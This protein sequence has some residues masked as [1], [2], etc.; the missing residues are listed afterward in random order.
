[1]QPKAQGVTDTLKKLTGTLGQH[2]NVESKT[3][4]PTSGTSAR[5]ALTRSGLDQNKRNGWRPSS[6]VSN[7]SNTFNSRAM[8]T[9]DGQQGNQ[10]GD[11]RLALEIAEPSGDAERHQT[12]RTMTDA[13]LV[14]RPAASEPSQQADVL[15]GQTKHC[16]LPRLHSSERL[17]S[18]AHERSL[19][20]L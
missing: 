18:R 17:Q 11:L 8:P 14:Q 15:L 19:F 5:Q 13:C 2:D 1:M 7:P 3:R 6:Q 12:A 16:L 20:V 4:L 10:A 9:A